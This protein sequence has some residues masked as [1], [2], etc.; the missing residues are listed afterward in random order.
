MYY[1]KA[2]SGHILTLRK[3]AGIPKI[4]IFCLSND[5]KSSPELQLLSVN[6]I[7]FRRRGGHN[8][9]EWKGTTIIK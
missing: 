9:S 3:E 1:M 8:F 4:V 6:K 7:P 2:W 5:A